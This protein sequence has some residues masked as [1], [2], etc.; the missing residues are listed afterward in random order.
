[1]DSMYGYIKLAI[2]I[3]VAISITGCSYEKE[4]EDVVYLPYTDQITEDI[5]NKEG[6]ILNYCVSRDLNG[7]KINIYNRGDKVTIISKLSNNKYKIATDEYID[8]EHIE[9][10][11][12][13][14]IDSNGVE[15]R[16]VS[17]DGVIKTD[18][19]IQSSLCNYAYNYWYLIP[20][21]IRD[22]FIKDGWAII[23]TDKS[24]RDEMNTE[25]DII[26]ITLPDDKQIKIMGTQKA[27]REALIHEVGHYIDI[28]LGDISKTIGFSSIY[29][30]TY[31]ELLN[32]TD[33]YT[34]AEFNEREAFAELIKHYYMNNIKI[35][36]RLSKQY[37]KL[38]ELIKR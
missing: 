34:V 33:N 4:V 38:F 14:F 6:Y 12:T 24:I 1:M 36:T 9:S 18:G 13:V 37:N 19:D 20:N 31:N 3:I 2:S 21:D 27:I 16:A 32:Y 25:Y 22:E 7:N 29:K 35:K 17:P 30:E 15:I 26:G 5:I 8:T 10:N 11:E 23:L 28:K